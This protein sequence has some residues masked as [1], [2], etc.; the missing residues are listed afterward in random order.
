MM[1][2]EQARS[3]MIKQQIYVNK[4][5]DEKIVDLF[6]KIPREQFVPQQ[7]MRL[8]FTD[9]FIPLGH[10]QVMMR[11]MEEA[12]I[13]QALNIQ[14]YETV[15][16][17][18]TGSGFMTALLAMQAKHVF[19]VDII[20]DFTQQA[21]QKLDKLDIRN[22]SLMTGNAA[23]SWA[24]A[25]PYDVIV[26]TGSLPILPHEFRQHLNVH[27]RIFVIEGAQAAMSAKLYSKLADDNWQVNTLFE[28]HIPPLVEAHLV[29]KF[30]F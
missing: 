28:T 18:G 7:Y 11:P 24:Q 22:V 1:D 16:E 2:I 8:A 19:S 21:Q 12:R 26:I 14:N 15:L 27:G 30:E 10:D 23:R 29:K 4:V 17:V 25:A 9:M 5:V 20:E 13:L 6:R 3:N